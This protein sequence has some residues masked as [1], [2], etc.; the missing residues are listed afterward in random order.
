MK[1]HC[2]KCGAKSEDG[3]LQHAKSCKPPME[4]SNIPPFKVKVVKEK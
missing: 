1:L 3:V 4:I 2:L